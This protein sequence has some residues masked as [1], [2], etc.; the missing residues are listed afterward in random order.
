M[1]WESALLHCGQMAHA[2]RLAVAA[3]TSVIELMANAG[4]AVAIEIQRRWSARP[5][6]VLCGPGNN[7]GDGFVVAQMLADAGWPV[8]L[9]LLGSIE[10]LPE[11]ARHHGT[12]WRGLVEPVSPAVLEGASLV[13]D[14]IF[15]AGLNRALA[16]P[17]RETLAAV[18][19]LRGVPLV[20]IDVPSGV[21]GDT[22]ETFGAVAADLTVT[23]FRKKPGHLL[24]PGRMLC[25]ET[26]AADI[27]IASSVLA[28]IG[29]E[30]FENDPR[31]WLSEL[32]LPE[33]AG[34]KY[35]RGHALIL[36][37]YPMTGAARLAARGAARAGAGLTT[38][39]VP[40]VAFPIYAAAFTSIMVHPLTGADDLTRLLAD[41]RFKALLIGPGADAN[42]ATRAQACAML[43][44]GRP[45][46]MDAGALTAFAEDTNA[47]TRAISS[48]ISRP[49][50]LTPHEGEFA[51]L[52]DCVGDKLS[53]CRAAARSSNAIIVLKG[54]DTVI[55]APN[56]EAIINS[57]A[58]ASLATAGSGDVLSGIIVGLLAQGMAPMSAAAA[59]VWIHGAAARE[60]GQGLIAEDL[61]EMLPA[62]LRKLHDLRQS[63]S[64]GGSRPRLET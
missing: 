3:G 19:T 62:V 57:N 31:H 58:P 64:S 2:D 45:I 10:R 42:E 7:G 6:V 20:A 46:A 1:T 30:T 52:F 51:R 16:S 11:A 24:L 56:G 15:G 55:A 17:V 23:F 41:Q 47:L 18:A 29:P 61:P 39:A 9:A 34:H 28:Q 14:A 50:V 26:V 43:G 36:G 12:Q 49:C 35:T 25:G 38:V 59:A 37:G 5:V 63:T 21:N 32:P 13:V 53:R 33:V 48:D 44:S 4:R 60:F 27:G 8:R 40:Q 22:G 54:S